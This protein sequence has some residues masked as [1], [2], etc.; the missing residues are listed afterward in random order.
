MQIKPR[1]TGVG[2]KTIWVE[3]RPRRG[4]RRRQGSRGAMGRGEY[5]FQEQESSSDHADSL[6][7]ITVLGRGRGDGFFLF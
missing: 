7:S 5:E 4:P 3:T 1:S 6:H 2:C